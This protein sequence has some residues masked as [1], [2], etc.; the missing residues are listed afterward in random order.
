MDFW[1]IMVIGKNRA[2]LKRGVRREMKRYAADCSCWKA[3]AAVIC[4]QI[5]LFPA[6]DDHVLEVSSRGDITAGANGEAEMKIR[7]IDKE[8]FVDA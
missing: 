8:V 2:C 5:D 3:I 7:T 6:D 1:N 4:A